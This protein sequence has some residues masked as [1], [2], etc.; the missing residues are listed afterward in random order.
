[1][2]DQLRKE[3]RTELECRLQI[4]H[5]Y[6]LHTA[7]GSQTFMEEVLKK[8]IIEVEGIINSEPL[9]YTSSIVD[10][11]LMTPNM[12]LMGHPGLSTP[13]DIYPETELLSHCRQ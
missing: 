12:L 5:L 6:A 3:W 10:P 9:G 7:L 11:N 4:Y 2:P 8:S 1:M 13:Q